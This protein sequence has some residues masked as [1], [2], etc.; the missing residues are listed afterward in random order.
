MG[1]K[2]VFA[3]L[4][5]LFLL[6]PALT[7]SQ[8][9]EEADKLHQQAIQLYNQ[10]R[11]D[12]AINLAKEVLAIRE[13]A[14]GP[15][16]PDTATSLNNLAGLYE[17]TGRYA[18]AE[19]LYKRS[20]AIREKVLGSDHPDTALGLNN[21]AF[22]YLDSG[23]LDEGYEIFKK[24][25]SFVGLGKY[26]L[27]K[28]DY[29][30]AEKEFNR[31]LLYTKKK[32]EP[33]FLIADHIGLGLSYEGMKDYANAKEHF[34]EAINVT[35]SQWK[36]LSPEA[37]KNFHTAQAGAGFTRIEAYEGL[38]RVLIQEKGK[39]YE[40]ASLTIAESVK[41]RLFLEMLATREIRGQT[42]ED[43]A[44]LKKDREYQRALM[45]FRKQLEV[46][47]TTARGISPGEIERIRKA[48]SDKEKE[49]ASFIEEV[50]LKG[51]ELSSL[52][53]ADPL[54]PEKLQGL[55]DHDTSFLEYMTTRDRTFAWLITKND[56]RVYEI[57]VTE[58][59][60][61]EKI[62]T[63]LLPDISN[64]RKRGAARVVVVPKE[65]EDAKTVQERDRNRQQFM[66][67]AQDLSTLLTS[68]I[69]KDIQTK[70]LIVVPHGVLHKLPFSLL[71]DNRYSL[72]IMPAA[73]VME[74]V[75]NKRKPGKDALF[76]IANP[77]TDYTPLEY[78]EKEGKTVSL[79]FPRKE[80]YMKEKATE[81]IV[82]RRSSPYNVIHF[83]SHGEFNERQPL[84]SGLVLT[85]DIENDGFL[86][87][88]EI[89]SLN[90]P[91]ANLVTLSA[92]ETALARIQG[93]DDMVG[94]SRG[95]I[96]AGTPSLLATLWSVDDQSTYILM[97]HFYKNWLKGMS[98]PEA[99]RQA[100]I[101][102]KNMPRYRHPF[103][104]APF[105]MIG[106]WK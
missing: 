34:Q 62:D 47:E 78:A 42:K 69:E 61:K 36:T 59:A 45:S 38:V 57:S 68:P 43:E 91:N 9:L 6:F 41:G 52:I 11:Y 25:N 87:V 54:S 77:A 89:F 35:E 58:K 27:L 46:M 32:G 65:R 30:H 31:S 39:G 81:T 60:L 64:T 49:Y 101:T 97:E 75:V 83:A 51:G 73:S 24:Q 93:G 33:H 67:H 96:Y 26:Y 4:V 74:F 3:A 28:E 103:F 22:L 70:N 56:I 40:K 79:L 2:G 104:W 8:S 66:V 105:V 94:L 14:L 99:L 18:E 90:L 102:L 82:K 53:T 37:K 76:L 85:K 7:F 20:L 63:L 71:T 86:Q 19:P 84:Q 98:K 21:L 88:H 13:K 5:F 95:F 29:P 100:Q 44:V 12:E 80:I 106:D 17:T 50:K 92:C 72:S 1:V 55:L 15:E 48:L 10:G 16:H 23:R